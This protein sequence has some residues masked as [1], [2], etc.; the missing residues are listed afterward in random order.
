MGKDHDI[1]LKRTVSRI[2]RHEAGHWLI[3]SLLGFEMGAIKISWGVGGNYRGFT[4]NNLSFPMADLSSVRAYAEKRVM[5]LY[6]G[7]LAQATMHGVLNKSEAEGFL[8]PGRSDDGSRAEEFIHLIRNLCFPNDTEWAKVHEQIQKIGDELF[9]KTADLVETHAQVIIGIG[10]MVTRLVSPTA[11][12][13]GEVELKREVI[14]AVPEVQ[15]ALGKI[16]Q[17]PNIRTP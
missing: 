17:V 16:F 10:G 9:D 12:L 3:G 8:T 15:K 6:A 7:H 14:R 11:P 1:A 2:S 13:T 4:E 5:V